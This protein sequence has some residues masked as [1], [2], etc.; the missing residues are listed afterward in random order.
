[1]SERFRVRS[2]A[3]MLPA[4]RPNRAASLRSFCGAPARGNRGVAEGGELVEHSAHRFAAIGKSN[5]RCIMAIG[6]R[7]HHDPEREA[8]SP[9]QRRFSRD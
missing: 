9:T 6:K 3:N 8:F 7:L 1:M 2:W 4:D 5:S